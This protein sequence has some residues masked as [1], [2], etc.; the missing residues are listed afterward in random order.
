MSLTRSLSVELGRG[1]RR[2]QRFVTLGGAKPSGEGR[3]GTDPEHHTY[4]T[5]AD[6]SDPDG[7][8]WVLQEVRRTDP[9]TNE[10]TA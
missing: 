10:E 4:N 8:T 1:T 3:P 6:F 9:V 2:F 5:F 7:N